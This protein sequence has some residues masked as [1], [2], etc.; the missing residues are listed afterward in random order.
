MSD[1]KKACP[2]QKKYELGKIKPSEKTRLKNVWSKKT[3][4]KKCPIRRKEKRA[5]RKKSVRS[6][7][8]GAKKRKNEMNLY[9][10]LFSTN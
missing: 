2:I 10:Y 3:G 4:E 9:L 8:Y 1:K 6:E 7:K 5:K